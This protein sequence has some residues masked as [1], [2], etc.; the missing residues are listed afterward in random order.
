LNRESG[1]EYV[2]EIAYGDFITTATERRRISNR[3]HTCACGKATVSEYGKCGNG[4]PGKI[5]TEKPRKS[6]DDGTNEF[7]PSGP[8]ECVTPSVSKSF[9]ETGNRV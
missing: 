4:K 1:K 5:G 6:R 2:I 9:V 8:S 7:I 3:V